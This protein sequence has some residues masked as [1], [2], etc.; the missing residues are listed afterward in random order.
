LTGAP[1][2]KVKMKIWNPKFVPLALSSGF[3]IIVTW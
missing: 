1:F 3:L 2:K